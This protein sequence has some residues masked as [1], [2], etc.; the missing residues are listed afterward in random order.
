MKRIATYLIVALVSIICN[1]SISAQEEPEIVGLLREE[2]KGKDIVISSL[3][4]GWGDMTLSKNQ[5][6]DDYG[7]YIIFNDEFLNSYKFKDKYRLNLDIRNRPIHVEDVSFFRHKISFLSSLFSGRKILDDSDIR[8]KYILLKCSLKEGDRIALCIPLWVLTV[9]SNLDNSSETRGV[10][11]VINYYYLPEIEELKINLSKGRFFIKDAFRYKAFGSLKYEDIKNLSNH[12]FLYELVVKDTNGKLLSYKIAPTITE[13]YTEP[14]SNREDSPKDI[15]SRVTFE[16]TLIKECQEREAERYNAI[17]P[18]LG[19]KLHFK[20]DEGLGFIIDSVC[21][22]KTEAPFY[23]IIKSN[24]YTYNTYHRYWT[25]SSLPIENIELYSDY[26]ARLQAEEERRLAEY[27]E[28][29]KIMEEQRKKEEASIKQIIAQKEA[30]QKK[31]VKKLFEMMA[32]R[33]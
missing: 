17:Q 19:K 11:P 15:L 27:Q 2:L 23:Y 29:K 25:L 9:R 8:G 33:L 22:V 18:F 10:R 16:D 6:G 14:D 12:K 13:R 20:G 26:E 1:I 28:N 4:E 24:D 3:D 7:R 31:C 32:G 21:M 5:D 30:S